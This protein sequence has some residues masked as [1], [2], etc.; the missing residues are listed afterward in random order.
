MLHPE[1][2]AKK[3]CANILCVC[4]K[5]G[6]QLPSAEV[7]WLVAA[8]FNH[9]IDYYARGEEESCHRWALRAMHLAEYVGDGGLLR[10]TLQD[11]FAKLQF[12]GLK[13]G[14]A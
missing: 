13:G 8:A 14:E 6:T 10:D 5:R 9:A 7:E 3:A 12:D 11:K 2:T 4:T 1:L